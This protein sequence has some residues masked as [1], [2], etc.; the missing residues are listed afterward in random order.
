[1]TNFGPK[2][3]FQGSQENLHLVERWT[4]LDANRIEYAVTIEDP[5]TWTRSWTVNQE[6]NRQNDQANRIYKEPRW[7]EG[8]YGLP[9]LLVG[10]RIEERAFAEKRGP[11]PATQCTAGCGGFALGFADS[12]ED[13]IAGQ[14]A[15]TETEEL[16]VASNEKSREGEIVM[17]HWL[18]G[19]NIRVA[20]A[21]AAVSAVISV[22]VTRTSSQ[23]TRP[24][25]T[26]DG[27]PN[28]SG[29]W[30]A[31]NEAHWDLQAHEARPGAVMQ[32]GVYPYEFARVPAA[33]VLALGAA[34]GVPGSTG[35]VQGDG[36]IPYTPEA[37]A[38][39][40]ENAQTGLTRPGTK[41]LFAGIPR[42]MYIPILS[43]C[44]GTN[45]I[46]WRTS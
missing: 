43:D 30:Q 35:V 21:A 20:V 23:A 26:S 33:P 7:H 14:I 8:N 36:Q 44:S 39:K 41:L 28:F 19:S 12:G 45:K 31:L 25:R 24:P 40:K 6:Y 18:R 5:T 4:R 1:M 10:A 16:G 17:R 38:I 37:A 15:R 3:Y 11:D 27:K 9:A 2:S 42:A 22:S 32:Q 46:R 29:I 34:G 13:V